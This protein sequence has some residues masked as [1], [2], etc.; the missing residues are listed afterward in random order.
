[1]RTVLGVLMMSM[2][3]GEAGAVEVDERAAARSVVGE[4][5]RHAFA[6]VALRFDD[7]MRA[8]LPVEKVEQAWLGLEN[9]SG[10]FTKITEV[11]EPPP[12]MGYRRVAVTCAFERGSWILQLAFD[13]QHRMAGLGFVPANATPEPLAPNE[14]P[15]TVGAPG[16][17][18]PAIL[19]MPKGDGPFPSVVLVH[20]S[21]P[22]DAD[23]TI[24]PNKPFRDLAWGLAARGIA[25][26]RYEKRTHAGQ[27]KADS[28]YTVNEETVDDARAAVALLLQT[29]KLDQK[30]IY[31]LGHSL[32]AMLAPRIAVE[33]PS[34]AGLI[35]LAG[36]TRPLE[37]LVL[38]QLKRTGDPKLIAAAEATVKAVRN[39]KLAPGDKV[40]FIG[41]EIPGSYFLDLRSYRPAAAAAA[42]SLPMLV[43]QGDRDIQVMLADYDGWVKAVGS[44]ANVKTK[45]YPTL[46]H[47]FMPGEGKSGDYAK[48][49]HV[50]DEVME[51]IAAF[52]GK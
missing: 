44:R 2:V 40:S 26:L 12:V 16:I 39:P 37:E 41:V 46:T 43:L 47:Q 9:R 4:F 42:L 18:L 24:G 49:A 15:L 32:G 13:A 1:M 33:N 38:E 28:R 11:A 19:S 25:V 5:S 30:R 48:P 29:E 14:R 36:N 35:L 31:V 27:L 20:G 6:E 8:M 50:A 22:L 21:G 23:E 17:K 51:D 10:K 7:K 3:V 45:R 52:I 34:V